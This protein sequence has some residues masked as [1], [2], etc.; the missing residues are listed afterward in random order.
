MSNNDDDNEELEE[1]EKINIIALGNG[2]VGKTSFIIRYTDSTFQ[3]I[4]LTTVG[5][6]FK[7]KFVKLPNQ[8]KL[9]VCF[10]DT[11]G[12]ERFKSIAVNTVRN[13]DGILLLYDITQEKTFEAISDWMVSIKETKG[14]NFPIILLGSK[15]DLE[16]KREVKKEE[17]EELAKK[18][19][20]SFYEI[21]NKDGINIEEPC[22]ELINKIIENR[23]KNEV[24]KEEMKIRKQSVRLRKSVSSKK[25]EKNSNCNCKK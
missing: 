9:K 5:I 14:D 4:Y 10:Y 15:C 2:N 11:S 16:E 3:Q 12:E 21:S 17:G 24:I 6:D 7:M 18:Y 23:E 19:N 1:E 25:I 20:I 13:A 22:T 8:K